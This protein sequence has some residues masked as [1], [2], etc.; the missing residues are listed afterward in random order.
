MPLHDYQCKACGAK[1]VD[2]FEQRIATPP[3]KCPT[4]A[5][6]QEIFVPETHLMERIW[7]RRHGTRGFRKFL[8]EDQSGKSIELDSMA[9]VRKYEK[10]TGDLAAGGIGQPE[11]FRQFSQDNSNMDANVFGS[12]NTRKPRTTT[13]RGIP[14]ISVKEDFIDAGEE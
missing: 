10:R 13:R 8:H 3:P 12:P 4:L 6:T 1:I 14:L 11:V 2:R 9:A 7:T 5:T